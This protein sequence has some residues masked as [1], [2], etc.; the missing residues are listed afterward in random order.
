MLAPVATSDQTDRDRVVVI[1]RTLDAAY[2]GKPRGS[3]TFAS[4]SET[5][6]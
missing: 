2:R 6:A 1:F 5:G 3:L 4:R